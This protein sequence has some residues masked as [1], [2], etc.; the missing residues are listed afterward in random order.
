M[1]S[2]RQGDV[3]AG[4]Q[5]ARDAPV[6]GR[7][8]HDVLAEYERAL[9]GAPLAAQTRRAYRSR[10]AGYL[11]WLVGSTMDGD[12]LGDPRVRDAAVAR[13]HAWL[14]AAGARPTTL[15]AT[16]TALDHF[17]QHLR[18][19][20][21]ATG[22]E[23]IPAAIRHALPPEQRQRLL[24]ALDE[25]E[26]ARDRAIAYTLLFTGLRTAELVALDLPDL[27]LG[28]A[29][30]RLL[31]HRPA[32]TS[33]RELP[34]HERPRPVLRAWLGERH[35]WSGADRTGAL[36][37]NRRG[38]RLTARSV[39]DLV[40]RLGEQAGL[41]EL[42]EGGRLTPQALRHTF[43]ASL[44]SAGADLVLVAA[45]MGHKRLDTTRRYADQLPDAADRQSDVLHA[46]SL[47]YD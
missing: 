15:N 28:E 1:V 12:P 9:A 40:A 21:A 37:L 39:V 25:Q 34:L 19:G 17:Y 20:P 4:R 24:R 18:L 44:L 26:S 33:P 29:G 35:R 6:T 23:R 13:Y 36:F 11:G 27:R 7:R 31:V 43:G 16:L 3:S 42:P 10:V 14:S 47:A 41:T 30:G 32:G 5:P 8:A 46:L 2:G 45:L 22:R 38:G